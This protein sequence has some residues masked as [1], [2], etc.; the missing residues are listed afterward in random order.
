MELVLVLLFLALIYLA[1]YYRLMVAWCQERNGAERE[2]G[3]A[4]RV[5]TPPRRGFLRPGETRY[6][7]RY[8]GTLAA[9]GLLIGVGVWTRYPVIAQLAGSG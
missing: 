9:L 7:R 2:R 3:G 1:V 4:L 6:Y 5:L 8:W